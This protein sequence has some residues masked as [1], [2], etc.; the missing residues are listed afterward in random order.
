[1]ES[2]CAKNNPAAVIFVDVKIDKTCLLLKK[3]KSIFNAS[4]FAEVIEHTMG[5]NCVKNNKASV[6]FVE[7]RI[8]NSLATE[9]FFTQFE[10]KIQKK[11]K[12]IL[13]TPRFVEAIE[14]IITS[15]CTK[16]N[17]ALVIFVEVRIDNTCFLL[18]FLYT[19]SDKNS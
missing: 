4:R 14:H 9:L 2:C 5:N 3:F 13:K 8:D 1:M 16:N 17:Q 15:S 10:I 12:C 18:N 7:I 6:T 19:I 11:F